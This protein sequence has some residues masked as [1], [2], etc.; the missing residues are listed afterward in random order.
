MGRIGGRCVLIIMKTT[1][2][3]AHEQDAAWLI[4]LWKAVHGGDPSLERVVLSEHEAISFARQAANA[5][6]GYVSAVASGEPEG[7]S[8]EAHQQLSQGLKTAGVELLSE[9]EVPG[10]QPAPYCFRW[11]GQT[12]CIPRPKLT[13]TVG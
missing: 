10:R 7:G 1:I 2:Q 11:N 3:L 6:I 12:I 9:H 4:A 8:A 13:H 5:L